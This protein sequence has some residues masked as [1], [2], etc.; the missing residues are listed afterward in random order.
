MLTAP[1]CRLVRRGPTGRPS[2]FFQQLTGHLG[3]AADYQSLAGDASCV[4]LQVTV[5]DYTLAQE[6]DPIPEQGVYPETQ[7]KICTQ[8]LIML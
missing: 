6:T 3:Y 4:S 7:P 1:A 2:F 5:V 8:V